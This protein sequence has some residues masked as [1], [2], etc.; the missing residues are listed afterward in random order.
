MPNRI[1]RFLEQE[2]IA[3][4]I[5]YYF[6][7]IYL[8]LS[9]GI[10]GPTLPS[11]AQQIKVSIGQMGNIFLIGSLGFTIGTLLGGR[12]M[13]RFRGHLVVGM[14]QLVGGCLIMLIPFSTGFWWLMA[15]ILV[16]GMAEG[17]ILGVNTLLVWTHREKA[18][19]FINTLHFCFGLGAF[20]SPLIVGRLITIPNGYQW[21][22]WGIGIFG[23][24]MGV[25]TI[26]LPG[27]PKPVHL[28]NDEQG[29]RVSIFSVLVISAALYLFFYVGAEITFGGWIYTY[30]STLSILNASSSAFL[31]SGFWLAFTMGRLLSIP[32]AIHTTPRQ[33]I[34]I[35]LVGAISIL[36]IL[37]LAPASA[38]LLWIAT[39]I[40]GFCL[41]PLW[42]MGFS[43]SGQSIPMTARISSVVLLGDSLGAMILPWLVGHLIDFSG[44]KSIILIVLGSLIFD[45]GAYLTLVNAG[46]RHSKAS[47]KAIS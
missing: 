10:N 31:T 26:F 41:A 25:R 12:W 20:V 44:A 24:L 15:I 7:F 16:K 21:A 35:A 6:L 17:L 11:V 30:A 46:K 23:I 5:Q 38:N 42:P 36:T 33:V 8:G 27:N 19:L 43:L 29:S 37:N 13:E 28:Q 47:L 22:F 2:S 1:S 34:P 14:G 39:I 18:G 32:A 9:T 45:L 40:L 4:T 3:Q